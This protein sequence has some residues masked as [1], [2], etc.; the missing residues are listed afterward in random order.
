MLAD[1]AYASGD[2]LDKFAVAGYGTAIKPIDRKPRITGGFTPSPSGG[3]SAP[4]E[5]VRT[6]RRPRPGPGLPLRRNSSGRR[7]S[8]DGHCDRREQTQRSQR[9]PPGRD[10]RQAPAG[11]ERPHSINP[12]RPRAV[13]ASRA[14]RTSYE[15]PAIGAGGC[16]AMACVNGQWDLPGGGQ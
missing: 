14:A 8:R 16:R 3:D 15:P 1:S 2:A 9:S 4:D 6:T 12:A 11:P 7:R 10:P 5:L 13:I